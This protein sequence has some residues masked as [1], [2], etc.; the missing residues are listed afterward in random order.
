MLSSL[1]LY[2]PIYRLYRHSPV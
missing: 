1:A 2:R